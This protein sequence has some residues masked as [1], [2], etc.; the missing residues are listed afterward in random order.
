VGQANKDKLTKDM[1]Q[2]LKNFNKALNKKDNFI[3]DNMDELEEL[4]N[5]K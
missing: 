4:V 1:E 5:S 3:A 2:G